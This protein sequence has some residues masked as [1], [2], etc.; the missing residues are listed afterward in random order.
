M[1]FVSPF[2]IPDFYATKKSQTKN[3]PAYYQSVIL[4]WL[5]FYKTFLTT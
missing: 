2:Y 1:N 5:F 4:V 3:L